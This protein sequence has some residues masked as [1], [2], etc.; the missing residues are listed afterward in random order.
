MK[1]KVRISNGYKHDGKICHNVTIRGETFKNVPDLPKCENCTSS[2]CKYYFSCMKDEDGYNKG[3]VRTFDCAKNAKRAIR[4]WNFVTSLLVNFMAINF[5]R[6]WA[7]G[8][9]KGTAALL[10]F[11][12]AFDIICCSIEKLV[13][14]LRDNYFYH[15]LKKNRAKEKAAE[16]QK[17]LAE[18]AKRI[19]EQAEADAKDPNRLK[20]RE[21]ETTL[22][23][24]AQISKNINFGECDEQVEFCVTKCREIIDHLNKDSSGYIRVESLLQVYLPEFYKI[25]AYYAEF[26]KAEAVEEDQA[27]KLNDTVNYFYNFLCKQKVE[28]IFDK[29]ATEIKF[30]AAA[31]TLRR[32]I[33]NRGGKL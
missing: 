32:E 1:E 3:V 28:A 30:N 17:R 9:F 23:Q 14:I 16:E 29:K 7:L 2:N 21:A 13:D 4:T 24:I 5:Y 11:L 10:A 25:L 18:E 12:V 8:F 26:E 27:K 31:D 22:T 15:K 6:T 19:K 20:I 33:E